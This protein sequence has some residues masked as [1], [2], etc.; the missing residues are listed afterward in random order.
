MRTLTTEQ[1]SA[2]DRGVVSEACKVSVKDSS[3]NWV[4]Y[5][6]LEGHDWIESCRVSDNIDANTMTASVDLALEIFD[7]NLSPLMTNN[8]LYVD[9]GGG[10]PLIDA[11]REIK[12]EL[13]VSSTGATP[14]SSSSWINVFEGIIDNWSIR[15]NSISLKCRDLGAKLLD[16]FIE[17]Q[18][19]YGDDAGSVD[20]EDV[21]QD[22]LDDNGYSSVT[23][24][25]PVSP[26]WA[27]KQYRQDKMPIMQALT[28]LAETLGWVV[29]Y[30]WDSGTS[31]W[32]LTFYEPDRTK[33][34]PDHTFTADDYKMLSPSLDASRIRNKVRVI[35]T[36]ST[37]G[38]RTT[39][40]ASDATSIARFG[41]LF[42][43]IEEGSSSQID[44][45]TEANT[46]IENVL[47]DLKDP[48]LNQKTDTNFGFPWAETGDLYRFEANAT[49][50]P[51]SHFYDSDQDLAVS[52]WSHSYQD[53]RGKT[54]M[55]VQGKPSGGYN[56]WL[57][58]EARPG[59]APT[60]DFVGPIKKNER[61]KYSTSGGIGS[62][63]QDGDARKNAF[64]PNNDFGFQSRQKSLTGSVIDGFPPD[65]WNVT[66]G[67]WGSGNDVY[68]STTV[69]QSGGRSIWF[70]GTN[71]AT[72]ESDFIPVGEND[73]YLFYAKM[74]SDST[75]ALD[76][77]QID[78]DWYDGSKSI[79]SGTGV[80]LGRI[81]GSTWQDTPSASIKAPSGARFAK[82]SVQWAPFANHNWYIDAI[83]FNRVNPNFSV[84]NTIGTAVT[85]AWATLDFTTNTWSAFND[86]DLPN[87]WY[88]APTP[89]LYYFEGGVRIESMTLGDMVSVRIM[90]SND[91]VTWV[92]IGY[93][94]ATASTAGIG[95]CRVSAI[96]QANSGNMG[97]Q[98]K[99]FR[100]DAKQDS[101]GSLNTSAGQKWTFFSGYRIDDL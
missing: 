59:N 98:Y 43:E 36:D 24:Y 38:E 74:Y 68:E 62:F 96:M 71:G 19:V 48:T 72:V 7:L 54:T 92:N 100:L 15:K 4:D 64:L 88:L 50:T 42:M 30:R 84:Y 16:K 63:H 70:S 10:D 94:E 39:L 85:S 41:T 52:Q 17:E 8:K 27:I 67:D 34:T 28:T 23:L 21:M 58:K 37:T 29:R 55:T 13:A 12:I 83:E 33:S 97:T 56:R 51:R 77:M 93:G 5:S 45:S 66:S 49:S 31:A 3:G 60:A 35:Y 101:G 22:I 80:Y 9:N 65:S 95:N 25:T 76:A 73:Y 90:G 57:A 79:L 32:R 87:D 47:E 1:Q 40:A 75:N 82:V 89:G 46:L 26:S 11:K 20:V 18:I 81:F 86:Y 14:V 91:T 61:T 69:T 44:T 78:V 2:L 6:T 53:G 99:Y